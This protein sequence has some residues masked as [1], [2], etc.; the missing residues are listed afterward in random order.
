MV[1]M[2]WD[3]SKLLISW[4]F[5]AQPSLGFTEMVHKERKCPVSDENVLLMSEVKGT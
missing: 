5:R 1:E 2:G 3:F 4:D